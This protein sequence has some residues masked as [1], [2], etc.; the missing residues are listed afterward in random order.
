V[1]FGLALGLLAGLTAVVVA[2]WAPLVSLDTAASD[3]ARTDLPAAWIAAARVVTHAGDG[4]PLLAAALALT[5]VL[6]MR[7]RYGSAAFIVLAA[8][9][10][11]LAWL[12]LR[13]V[14]GRNRPVDNH[15]GLETPAFPSGHAVHAATAGLVAVVLLWPYLGRLG[16]RIAVALAVVVALAVGVTRVVLLAHWPSDV[17]GGYL[18]ATVLVLPLASRLTSRLAPA[19]S[20]ASSSASTPNPPMPAGTNQRRSRDTDGN[21][22]N[23]GTNGT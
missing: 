22:R 23:A 14:V 6:L 7:K 10:T 17:L 19:T 21:D 11:E 5:A 3:A 8:A 9:S 2:G 18:L 13:A 15:V 20:S 12:G 16:R 4:L 1:A